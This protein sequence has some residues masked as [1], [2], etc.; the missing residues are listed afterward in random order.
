MERSDILKDN[1]KIFVNSTKEIND[2]AKRPAS[3]FVV[4]NLIIEN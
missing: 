1:G 4:S 2:N 3:I